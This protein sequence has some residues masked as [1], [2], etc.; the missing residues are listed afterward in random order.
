MRESSRELR[1]ALNRKS[2][3]LNFYPGSRRSETE[4]CHGRPM[5]LRNDSP[6][7]VF[8]NASQQKLHDTVV[9][10]GRGSPRRAGT[11]TVD[12]T[13]LSPERLINSPSAIVSRRR[14]GG[15]DKRF[16]G[17]HDGGGD[18]AITRSQDSRYRTRGYR[19][20]AAPRTTAIASR[21]AYRVQQLSGVS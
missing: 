11:T 2:R 3:A 17:S 12:G 14:P 21:L 1:R 19:R 18:S 9:L 8:A 15:R 6:R 10:Y 20:H 4:T 13:A 5:E 7:H 16:D